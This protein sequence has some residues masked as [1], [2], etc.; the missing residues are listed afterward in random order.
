MADPGTRVPVV[1]LVNQAG[2]DFG[3]ASRFGR[4]IPITTENVNPFNIDRMMVNVAL[5]LRNA[6]A[7]DFLVIAGTPILNAIVVA[8]W[9]ARFGKVNLLLWGRKE[10][11]YEHR[12]LDEPNLK[13]IATSEGILA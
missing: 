10:R 1:W 7:E 4:I 13:R 2:H 9:L 12:V 11:K 5:R 8:M 3:D 6:D